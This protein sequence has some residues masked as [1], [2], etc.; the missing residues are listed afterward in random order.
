MLFRNQIRCGVLAWDSEVL[1]KCQPLGITDTM[2]GG[3]LQRTTQRKVK[4]EE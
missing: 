2:K 4:E 3:H 1:S